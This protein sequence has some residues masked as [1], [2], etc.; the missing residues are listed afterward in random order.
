MK[1][2]AGYILTPLHLLAFGLVLGIFHPIQWLALKLGGYNAHKS[3]VD[4]MNLCLMR[5][6]WFLGIHCRFDLRYKMPTDRPLIIVSNHQGLFDIPPFFWYFRKNHV[7]FV[8]KIELARGIPSISFNL[9]HGGSALIDRDNPRQS[10]PALKQFGE[11]IEQNKY[12]ACIFP[13]GTR[14]K[15]G[16]PGNFAPTGFKML[17]KNIPSAL[18]VPVTINHVWKIQ[19]KGWYPMGTFIRPVWQVHPIIDPKGR[20]AD[21]VI[22]ETEQVIKSAIIIEHPSA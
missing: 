20:N 3:V 17:L 13:E 6:L 4:F 15:D 16:V 14:S 1:V 12:A 21:E 8:S 22:A 7:K 9:R 10:M 18:V 2:L 5:T 11:Y 19:T